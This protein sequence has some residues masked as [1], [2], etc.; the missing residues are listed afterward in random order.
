MLLA[1]VSVLGES[2]P[3]QAANTDVSRTQ[4][5]MS[6][7]HKYRDWLDRDY[8]YTL[9]TQTK[10]IGLV[11]TKYHLPVAHLSSSHHLQPHYPQSCAIDIFCIFVS[12]ITEQKMADRYKLLILN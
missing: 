3:P 10:Y 5:Q 12:D 7:A 9:L 11:A 1:A 2:N 8:K 4:I 6:W